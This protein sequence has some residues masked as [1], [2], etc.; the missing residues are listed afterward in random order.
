MTPHSHAHHT[1]IWA[2]A[3][4]HQ[5]AKASFWSAI[6]VRNGSNVNNA[7]DHNCLSLP[8]PR[9]K[10]RFCQNRQKLFDDFSR[11]LFTER[12]LLMRLDE[13]GQRPPPPCPP[14]LAP[15]LPLS[16]SPSLPLWRPGCCGGWPSRSPSCPTTLRGCCPPPS[17]PPPA[18]L[19][20]SEET[21]PLEIV[22]L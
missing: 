21:P 18:S 22:L 5:S 3:R 16:P 15:S 7:R 13:A 2:R 12:K 6:L 14:S 1:E 9:P 11:E 4:F 19:P 10:I 17:A 8:R 20:C